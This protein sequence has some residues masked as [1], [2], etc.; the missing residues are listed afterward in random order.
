MGKQLEKLIVIL[1]L[2]LM[3]S[4]VF[5]EDIAQNIPS[6]DPVVVTRKQQ[7]SKNVVKQPQKVL[8][9]PKTTPC[10]KK[11]P[12]RKTTAKKSKP[13][14]KPQYLGLKIYQKPKAK[15]KV[16]KTKKYRCIDDPKSICNTRRLKPAEPF[17]T[18]KAPRYSRTYSD[19]YRKSRLPDYPPLKLAKPIP[20]TT[21]Y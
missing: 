20:I 4:A 11:A 17:Y 14:D 6:N 21:C 12:S 18:Y 2:L 9:T 7:E 13:T 15:T 1:G 3:G 10:C 8:Q 19:R 16:V 5:A